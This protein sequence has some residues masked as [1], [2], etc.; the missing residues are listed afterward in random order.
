M[1][2]RQIARTLSNI[3]RN[4]LI[5]HVS[6]PLPFDVGPTRITNNSLLAEGLLRRLDGE[7]VAMRPTVLKLSELGRAV[8]CVILGEYADSLVSC[9]IM[10]WPLTEN[11]LSSA[12][13]ESSR[14][15]PCFEKSL[16]VAAHADVSAPNMLQPV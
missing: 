3:K 16:A 13:K 4:R 14:R 11:Q 10:E 6:G 1:S 12:I 5:A 15:K 7:N 9:G 8:V 2:P